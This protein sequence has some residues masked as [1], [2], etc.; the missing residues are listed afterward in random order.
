MKTAIINTK[1]WNIAECASAVRFVEYTSEDFK[2][3]GIIS[4]GGVS[5]VHDDLRHKCRHI[6]ECAVGKCNLKKGIL[7]NKQTIIENI[8]KAK[9]EE[10]M[11]TIEMLEIKMNAIIKTMK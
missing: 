10:A 3:I 5:V 2:N 8:K 9:L 11:R 1:D 7:E 4:T 6:T